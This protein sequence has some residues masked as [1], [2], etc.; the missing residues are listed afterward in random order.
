[1]APS[2]RPTRLTT[3]LVDGLVCAYAP[4]ADA[5]G[6]LTP[7]TAFHPVPADEALAHTVAPDLTRAYY[8]TLD[9]AVC[10]TPDGTQLW[11]SRFE[12]AASHAHGHRPDCQLSPDGQVLW[13]YRPDDMAGRGR[14]DQWIAVDATD[15]TT[16]AHADLDTA[17]HGGVHLAH[18]A[19]GRILLNVGE[20]QDATTVYHGSL[21]DGR[22]D[23]VRYPW[24]D[25]CLIDVS[26]DGHHFLTVDHAQHD[27][28]VHTFPDGEARFTLS[29]ADFGHDPDT[30]CLEWSGGYLDTDTILATLA[31]EDENEEDWFRHYRVH[32]R[33][34]HIHGPV[35]THAAHPYDVR[36]LGDGS[37]LTAGP[38]GHPL[39]WTHP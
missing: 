22:I 35:D 19:S 37:W 18:P 7:A 39:R 10:V 20:G 16:L 34:G 12:P 1:M 3:R 25:R 9:A 28:T 8:T 4:T 15:G 27:L 33:T 24:D 2:P 11:R 17:G 21:T 6:V 23:L 13:I 32:A 31:G 29:A 5:L 30:T 14:P 26:P 36:P 38:T